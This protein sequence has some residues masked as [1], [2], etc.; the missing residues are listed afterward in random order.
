MGALFG[1]FAL[2][3]ASFCDVH[4]VRRA[5]GS[6]DVRPLPS[7]GGQPW[8]GSAALRLKVRL[9]HGCCAKRPEARA[10]AALQQVLSDQSK[11][12][13]VAT[14]RAVVSHYEELVRRDD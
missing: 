10:H 5:G 3:A 12:A 8:C 7:R 11:L 6:R 4:V 1:C 9:E 2:V 14:D 13:R